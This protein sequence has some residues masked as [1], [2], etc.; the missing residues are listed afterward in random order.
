ME[1]ICKLCGKK[2]EKCGLQYEYNDKNVITRM[3][4]EHL[5]NDHKITLEEY[6]IQTEFNG[7]AP[8]CECGCGEKLIFCKKNA[9]WNP[10]ESFGHYVHCG[11]VGRHNEKIINKNKEHY[12]N[13]YENIELYGISIPVFDGKLKYDCGD[14]E[15][16]FDREKYNPSNEEE[17][18]YK[19]NID[20]SNQF[21]ENYCL[22]KGSE[23]LSSN[24][25]CCW[26]EE[27][28]SL[29]CFFF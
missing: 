23:L 15:Q 28:V 16:I 26:C 13:K 22:N 3:F 8:T 20:C 17:K 10:S 21:E 25:Q 7:N 14:G 19:D 1:Y 11:H 5:K 18:M 27:I 24:F 2:F 4:N 6:I 29:F 9:I 12:K